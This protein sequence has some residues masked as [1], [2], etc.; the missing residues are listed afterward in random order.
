MLFQFRFQSVA[1][2]ITSACG[3]DSIVLFVGEQFEVSKTTPKLSDHTERLNE[4][5]PVFMQKR[6]KLN[7]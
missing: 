3:P 2:L 7:R 5:A 6:E 4:S 1:A